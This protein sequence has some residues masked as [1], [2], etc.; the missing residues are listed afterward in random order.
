M[1]VVPGRQRVIRRPGDLLLLVGHMCCCFDT[2]GRTIGGAG[3][4]DITCSVGW[5]VLCG[6][7]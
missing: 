4:L 5:L 1:V 6:V 7:G 3:P 2:Q